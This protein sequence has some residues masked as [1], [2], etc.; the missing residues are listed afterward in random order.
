VTRGA[1]VSFRGI[2]HVYDGALPVA[3]LQDI[4]CDVAVGQLV[5]I[6]GPSGCGKSTLLRILAGLLVPTAG[7]ATVDGTRANGHPGLVA[8]QPQHDL[9]MPWRRV[10]A[11]ATLGAEVAGVPRRE[12]RRDA[13]ALFQ[14]FGLAGFERA[15]PAT[16]SGGMRQRVALLRAF[17]VPRPVLL[18]DEPFGALDAITRREMQAWLQEVWAADG[19]TVV[20]VTHDVEEALLLADRVLV[21]SPRPGRI[22]LDMPVQLPRP[23]GASMVVEPPFVAAKRRLLTALESSAP[24]T[25]PSPS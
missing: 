14:R 8:F 24:P 3:A 1:P 13:L 19:R 9:L 4:E 25:P 18:L 7:V 2:T 20:L 12:A 22:V 5:A 16:L 6:V 23:R 17:L 10:V 11:N 21:M 15:W